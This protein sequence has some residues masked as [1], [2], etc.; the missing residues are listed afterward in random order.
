[1]SSSVHVDNKKKDLLIFFKGP[2][3]GLDN[4]ENSYL[5]LVQKLLNL[6][7]TTLKLMQFYYVLETF[8]K[9]FL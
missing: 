4:G 2:T 5:L 7:Q 6:K 9:I 3:Q 8:Q 1:M